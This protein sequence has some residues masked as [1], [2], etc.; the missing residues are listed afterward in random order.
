MSYATVLITHVVNDAVIGGFI[1]ALLNL[2]QDE[3]C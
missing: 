3:L 1:P 2:R